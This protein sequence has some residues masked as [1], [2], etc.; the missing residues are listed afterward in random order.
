MLLMHN[1]HQIYSLSPISLFVAAN[2]PLQILHFFIVRFEFH[3]HFFNPI[4]CCH[5]I[6]QLICQQPAAIVLL[7]FGRVQTL[8]SRANSSIYGSNLSYWLYLFIYFLSKTY[9]SHNYWERE[10]IYIYIYRIIP[11][12]VRQIYPKK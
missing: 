10:P 7:Q 11:I 9:T 5:L 4:C 8:C 1:I 2:N 12:Q 6:C 3:S